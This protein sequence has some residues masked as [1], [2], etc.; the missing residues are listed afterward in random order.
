MCVIFQ[1][2][3]SMPANRY[4]TLILFKNS[5]LSTTWIFS[6]TGLFITAGMFGY[7]FVAASL[8][9]AIV[10]SFFPGG[11]R[12]PKSYSHSSDHAILGE[13]TWTEAFSRILVFDALVESQPCHT[14][15][16]TRFTVTLAGGGMTGCAGSPMNVCLWVSSP[17]VFWM[18]ASPGPFA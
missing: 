7:S 18:P 9:S 12:I 2:S 8:H 13:G 15:C 3:G 14:E 17:S 16:F 10:I 11:D 6:I 5:W 4:R 1:A